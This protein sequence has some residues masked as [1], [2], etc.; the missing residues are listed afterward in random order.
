MLPSPGLRLDVGGTEGRDYQ[1][2]DTVFLDAMLGP[3]LLSL[4]PSSWK[5][6]Y[7][8][9]RAC[10][11]LCTDRKYSESNKNQRLFFKKKKKS[12]KVSHGPIHLDPDKN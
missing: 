4:Q 5:R 1:R 8:V 2:L 9:V 12:N 7:S 11:R 10:V 6:E 3:L